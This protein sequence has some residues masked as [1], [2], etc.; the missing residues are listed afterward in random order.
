[1]IK[2]QGF[3][4]ILAIVVFALAVVASAGYF[5]SKAKS[6]TALDLESVNTVT[7]STSTPKS[8][9][10]V[11]TGDSKL[12]PE[13]LQGAKPA[14]Q[15][16]AETEDSS[17]QHSSSQQILSAA[18]SFLL[19]LSQR[20]GKTATVFISSK[21]VDFY[22][23]LLTDVVYS[24][25]DKLLVKSPLT[26]FM[27]A[28][29]RTSATQ[30]T[31]KLNGTDLFISSVSS[32]SGNAIVQKFD[33]NELILVSAKEVGNKVV[34]QFNYKGKPFTALTFI[35]ENGIW[36]LDYLMFLA[37]MDVVFE[38]QIQILAEE[39]NISREQALEAGV[40]ALY[41]KGD[42]T[43]YELWTPLAVRSDLQA[44]ENIKMISYIDPVYAFTLQYPEGWIV[45][46][47]DADGM[48]SA[49]FI[50]PAISNKLRGSVAVNITRQSGLNLESMIVQE[51]SARQ[52]Q[53]EAQ[54]VTTSKIQ[55]IFQGHPAYE[56]ISTK[57]RTFDGGKT[58]LK[59]KT[60]SILFLIGDLV[61]SIEYKHNVD[62]FDQFKPLGDR[63]L[64]TILI[65]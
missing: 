49:F 58:Y 60:K 13:S 35:S 39:N 19:A 50:A 4:K 38:T 26:V 37:S 20:D 61:Y 52:S 57:L 55:I 14:P 8:V 64:N 59:Q 28:G 33:P 22:G 12:S 2:T 51:E 3:A 54:W 65:R 42:V 62:D 21:V 5:L 63:I 27:V 56:L 44:A 10:P 16:K 15:V 45:D 36:K 46:V 29:I 11:S 31:V 32:G 53:V 25:K 47:S 41:L 30:E 18:R 6:N 7:I 34:A 23:H 48:Y 9:I 40:K 17:S 43:E 1:M 24:P